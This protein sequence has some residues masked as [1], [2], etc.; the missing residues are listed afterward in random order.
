MGV[1][2]ILLNNINKY[3]VCRG[4]VECDNRMFPFTPLDLKS[5]VETTNKPCDIQ[6]LE[7]GFVIRL[8]QSVNEYLFIVS[9]FNMTR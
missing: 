2:Y 4:G 5:I 7:T 3:D 1:Q 6:F 8:R 9:W